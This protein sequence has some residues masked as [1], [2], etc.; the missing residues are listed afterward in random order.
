MIN[1]VGVNDFSEIW[2][3]SSRFDIA[4]VVT[5][6]ISGDLKSYTFIGENGVR[7]E[8]DWPIEA[9]LQRVAQQRGF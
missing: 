7:G 5:L 9:V 3:T 8:K 6:S 4:L 2:A 1:S